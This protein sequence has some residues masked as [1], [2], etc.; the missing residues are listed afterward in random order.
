VKVGCLAQLVNVIAP[1]MTEPGGPAWRQ[2]IFHPFAHFSNLG[3]GRVLRAT[4][5]SP[6]YAASYFDPRGSQ[7]LFFPL[8]EV[9]YLKFAAV[10]DEAAGTLTLFALNRSLTVEMPLRVAVEGFS[11]L[12]IERALVMHDTDLKAVNTKAEPDRVKPSA[13]ADARAEGGSVHATL[14]PTSWNVIWIAI[15]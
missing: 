6:T 13:L 2:T 14:L 12:V 15:S 5:D 9:P 4:I 1:I 8:P 3:R 10:H 11:N 7:D